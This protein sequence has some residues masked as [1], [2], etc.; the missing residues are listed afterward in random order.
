MC[1]PAKSL[2]DEWRRIQSAKLL[3]GARGDFRFS[4]RPV[5][6]KVASP[7]LAGFV[8]LFVT[9]FGNAVPGFRK[10]ER[11][12]FCV[13]KSVETRKCD[14]YQDL[15]K[16]WNIELPSYQYISNKHFGTWAKKLH[17]KNPLYN[18]SILFTRQSHRKQFS[19]KTEQNWKTALKT[20]VI[21]K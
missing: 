13:R 14:N 6:T 10:F 7:Q 19:Y 5:P 15:Y 18:K 4:N 12:F 2:P 3:P 1:A 16:T 21:K 17:S 11:I 9:G 8:K 20:A